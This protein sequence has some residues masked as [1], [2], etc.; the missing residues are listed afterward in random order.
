[1]K[2]QTYGPGYVYS[3]GANALKK[4]KKFIFFTCRAEWKIPFHFVMYAMYLHLYEYIVK[5]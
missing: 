1:M 3:Q 4:L 5:F 2:T